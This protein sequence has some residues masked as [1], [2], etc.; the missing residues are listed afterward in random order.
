[1]KLRDYQKKA[2]R[3][4][5]DNYRAGHLHQVLAMPTGSGKTATAADIIHKAAQKGIYSL[6]IVDRIELVNQAADHLRSLGL[7]VGIMQG[8]NTCRHKDDEVIVATVQTLRIKKTPPRNS[9]L[10]IIDECHVL[11]Q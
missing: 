6:F 8:E 9:K 3:E 4:I 5:Y 2:I 10:V 1:M 7:K 11:H